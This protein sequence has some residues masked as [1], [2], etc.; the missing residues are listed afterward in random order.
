MGFI[1]LLYI[2]IL[3]KCHAKCLVFPTAMSSK[4]LVQLIE[5]L[6]GG[7]IFGNSEFAF[8]FLLLKMHHGPRNTRECLLF[9]SWTYMV[10]LTRVAKS[11]PLET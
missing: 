10:T 6:E 8:A 5:T 11:P 4:N 2:F 3:L 9:S 7:K 1:Y